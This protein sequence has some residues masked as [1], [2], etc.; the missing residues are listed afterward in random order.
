MSILFRRGNAIK[1]SEELREIFRKERKR[2]DLTTTISPFRAFAEDREKWIDS[3]Y[4][5]RRIAA[6][7]AL[8]I[9]AILI[10]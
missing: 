10:F 3:T 8:I 4:L 1:R 5:M 2:G 6:I 7:Q 9:V